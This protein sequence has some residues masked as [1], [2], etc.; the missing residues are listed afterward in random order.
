MEEHPLNLLDAYLDGELD[1]AT[2]ASIASHVESCT[3]CRARLESRRALLGSLRAADVLEQVPADLEAR[4]EAQISRRSPARYQASRWPAA[5]A[6]G[7]MLAIGGFFLGRS[8]P[9][10]P[11]FTDELVTAHIR[12]TLGL[13]DVDVASSDHHTVK[14]WLSAQVPFSPP[15]PEIVGHNDVLLGGR[16]DFVHHTRMAAVVYRH[17]QHAVNV[18]VWPKPSISDARTST[19]AIDGFRVVRADFGSFGVAIVSDMSGE[20]LGAFRERWMAAAQSSP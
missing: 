2:S 12:A 11:G 18:F 4:I 5:L 20:E 3:E 7:L 15:V 19:D 6:A 10:S 16:V 13:H 8:L 1:A 17:G 9:G 14:P